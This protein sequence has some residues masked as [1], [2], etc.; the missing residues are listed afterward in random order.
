MILNFWPVR[1]DLL[2]AILSKTVQMKVMQW[3]VG[4]LPTLENSLGHIFRRLET[5]F[6]GSHLCSNSWKVVSFL[7]E[8]KR[9]RLIVT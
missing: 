8:D 6:N 7:K 2:W 3:F 9:K 5:N 1:D 4:I